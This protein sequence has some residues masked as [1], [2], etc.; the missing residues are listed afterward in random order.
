M[1]IKELHQIKKENQNNSSLLSEEELNSIFRKEIKKINDFPRFLILNLTDD[2]IRQYYFFFKEIMMQTIECM[3]LTDKCC[4]HLNVHLDVYRGHDNKLYFFYTKCVKMERIFKENSYKENYLYH[5]Y[6]DTFLTDVKL[7]KK[8][9]GNEVHATK[10]QLIKMFQNK[11]KSKSNTG[12]YIYGTFGIGKTYCSNAFANLFAEKLNKKIC[13]I[14]VPDFVN[15]LKDGFNNPDKKIENGII[16]QNAQNAD[17]LFLDD[18]GAEYATDWFY[19]NIL[20]NLLNQRYANNKITYF[21]SNLSIDELEKK[22]RK[23]LKGDDG[24]LIAG[25]IIDR[26][27]SLVDNN[28]ILLKGNNMR[29]KKEINND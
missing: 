14:Y 13:F 7:D 4:N 16:I 21:N 17:V 23:S 10:N 8:W 29:H 27:K 25:R 18:I 15:M 5:Y 11:I 22:I 20:L 2:E 1:L 24:H 19:S 12:I 28:F 9:I 6:S 3:K 26:I